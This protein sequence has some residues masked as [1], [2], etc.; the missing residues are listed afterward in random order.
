M[1]YLIVAKPSENE[2]NNKIYAYRN[3]PVR[4]KQLKR[5]IHNLFYLE[6]DNCSVC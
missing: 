5:N 3:D 1:S 2:N 6:P 4:C